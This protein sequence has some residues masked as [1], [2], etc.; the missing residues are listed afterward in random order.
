MCDYR[1][2]SEAGP[3]PRLPRPL[4]D[5]LVGAESPLRG[6][7]PDRPPLLL[8]R[9]PALAVPVAWIFAVTVV[10]VLALPHIHLGP[11]LVAA[12]ALPRRS[13]AGSSR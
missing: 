10:D 12:P 2:G 7:A 5:S 1:G 4:F 3:G 11:P 6:I 9:G 8:R 13:A